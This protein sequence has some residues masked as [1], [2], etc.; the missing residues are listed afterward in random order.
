MDITKYLNH[1]LACLNEQKN[2]AINQYGSSDIDSEN[3]LVN[4]ENW[5]SQLATMI[6]IN[7][8]IDYVKSIN[9]Y[10]NSSQHI[11]RITYNYFDDVEYLQPISI[12]IY[13][14]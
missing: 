7:K 5:Y 13:W 2:N 8:P 6:N 3:Y 14:I 1:I 10:Q 9:I 12:N 11:Y 4:V